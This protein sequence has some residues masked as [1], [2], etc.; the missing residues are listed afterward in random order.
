M[1][2]VRFLSSEDRARGFMLLVCH[3][4]VRTLRNQTFIVREDSLAVLDQHNIKYKQVLIT[5][6][7]EVDALRNTPTTV[8]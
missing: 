1:V 4:T 7:D 8:L 5:D 3:G 2:A 6:L